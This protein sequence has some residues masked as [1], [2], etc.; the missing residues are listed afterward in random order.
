MEPIAIIGIS[1]RFPG[2][3]DKKAFWQLLRDGVDAI[4]EIPSDRPNLLASY[5]PN[6]KEAGKMSARWGGFLEQVDRFDPHFFG[7]SQR[8]AVA[9]DPQQ[10]L[11][12]EVSW[13]SLEDAGIAPERLAGTRTGVFIGAMWND[14]TQMQMKNPSSIDAYTGSGSGGF[15]M[16]NRLSYR[17]N[18]HGPSMTVDTGC[19]SSLAAVH[20]AC[21][22]L[23]QSE[24][25]LALAGGVNLMLEPGPSVFYTKAGLIAIDGRCKTFD[26]R[27]NG[28]V[29]GEGVG[30]V[31]LKRLSSALS[32]GDPIYAVI[33][34]SAVNHDGLTNGVTAPSQ[35]AQEA[36]LR[37]AYQRAGVSPGQVQYVEAHGTGTLLG[38][39]IEAKALGGVLANDRYPGS[40]CAIG[41]VKTNIGHLEAAAGIAAL[42]KVALALKYRE[43]PPSLHFQEPNPHIPFDILPLRVQQTLSPW[44]KKSGSAL[45]GVSS[46]G[47]GGTNVHMVL[48]EAPVLIPAISDV[49]RPLH[50]L[51]LSAKSENALRAMACCYEA[52]LANHSKVSLVDVCF[53]ANTGRSHFAHRLAL[54]VEST[55]TLREQ[56]SAFAARKQPTGLASGYVRSRKQ[57]KVAFLF[58]GQ[59][60]QYVGMGRQLYDTQPTFRQALERCD[61]LLRPYL[62]QPLLSVL[63]PESSATS[64]LNETA[65]TQPALF[66]LEYALTQLWKLWGIEPDVVMGHSVGE[67][68]AACVAGVF[69]LED[70]L[71]LIATRGQL[72]QR[73][74]HD[75][76]MAVVFAPEA[77]VTVAISPY[78]EAVSIAAINGPEN[79][80]ISGA[81]QAVQAVLR[82]MASE[83]VRTTQLNVS[84]AF[85]SPLMEPMLN[86][87]ERT[88]AEVDY[89]SPRI[90]LI[91]NLT[92]QVVGADELMLAEYWR[93]HIRETVRFSEG[94]EK[95]H[96]QGYDLFVE[97]G[98]SP[99]LSGMGRRCLPEGAG[100]WL[101]SLKK[102]QEDWLQLLDSLRALY[103]GGVEVNWSGFDRDYLR[104]RLSLPT[105]PFERESFWLQT[106]AV[107][108]SSSRQRV[109]QEQKVVESPPKTKLQSIAGQATAEEQ[110]SK[111]AREKVHSNNLSLQSISEA[112]TSASATQ[113]G[114]YNWQWYPESFVES[115]EIPSGAILILKDSQ[116]IAKNLEKLFDAEQYTIYFVASGQKFTQKNQRN[117][118]INPA[119]PEDYERLIRVLKEDGLKITAAIHLWNYSQALVSRMP[120]SSNDPVLYEGVY[121]VLFLGQALMKHYRDCPIDLLVVTQ[122]AYAT[123]AIESLQGLH[124]VMGA[125][126]AQGL[127]Q[128]NATIQTKVVDVTPQSLSSETLAKILFQEM[129]AK[130]SEE[131]I[132]A[133]RQGQRLIRTLER[134]EVSPT[135]NSQ[136]VLTAGETWLITGGTSDVG[137][138]IAKGL[139]SQAPLNLV[140][141]GRHPLPPKK[142]WDRLAGDDT[143]AS[144]RIRV[145]QDL[146]QLGATVMYQAIDVTDAEGMEQLMETIRARFG[147]LDGVIH[148]AGVQDTTSFKLSQKKP[149]TV[150]QV[151]APKVQGTIILDN[152]TQDEPLKSFVVISSAAASKAEWGA[153]LGDYAAANAFLDNYA[154]YRTQG[155]AS[156]RSL[157]VNFSLW[158]DKG[159][160]KI[161]GFALV[162]VAKAKGLNLL[163]PEQAVH[164]FIKALS[165]DSSSV[166]HI[167]DL[168]EQK[169]VEVAPQSSPVQEA[170]VVLQN[171]PTSQPKSKNLRHLVQEILAQYLSIPQEQ[172]E[173]H[174]TFQEL[175]L[176]SIGAIEAIKQLSNT[177]NEEL[178]PTLLFEYQT[179]NDLADYLERQY[180]YA[181]KTVLTATPPSSAEASTSS[182]ETDKPKTQNL[183]KLSIQEQEFKEQD[184]AIIGMAC[185]VPGA[186][187]LEQYWDLLMAGKSAIREVP[188]ERW[189]S[190]DYFEENGTSA[191]TTY[192]KHGGFIERPFD[193]DAMFF[194]ISPREA[195]AIDPQQRLFLEVAWQA[196]QQAGYGGRYRTQDIGV[197]VGCGQNNYV[198]HFINYQQYAVLRRR[199]QESSWFSTLSPQERKR[200]LKTLTEVLQPSEILPETAAGNELNGIAA[201]VSHCLDLKGPSLAVSTACSSSLVALHLA[202]ESLHAG[203]TRMAIVGGVNLNLSPSPYTFLSKVKALSPTGTCYPFDRRA[204]GMV[205]GEGA[206]AVIL[207]PLK[208]AIEDGD[209]IH[210]VIKGSA[211]NNDGHSQGITAPNPRG[212]AEAIRKAYSNAGIDPQTVSYVE[213]HG[214]GTLLGDP[215]EIEG[216]T[217]AF[218]TFTD[219]REFCAI[220]SVKSSIGHMLSAS[221]IV[222][223]IKVAL[224]MQ[225]GKIPGTLGFQ[226]SNPHINFADTPFYAVGERSMSWSGNGSPFRAGVNGFG[227]GGTN[228]HVI[229]EQSPVLSTFKSEANNSSPYLLFLTARN[230]Q[231]LKKVAG[232]LR[233]H[234]L[235]NP[236]QEASQVCFTMNNAQRELSNKA[237]LLVNDRQHMLD[238]LD[239]ICSENTR[240]YIYIGRA[241]PQR[242]TP[243][244][245]VI[246]GSSPL[247]PEEVEILGK[248]FPDF[249][250]AYA[251]CQQH[252]VHG[253]T[254]ENGHHRTGLAGK[255]YAFAV[256]YAL[257]QLLMSLELQ[258]TTLLAQETGILV[259]A[260]LVGMMTLEQAMTLLVQLETHKRINPDNVPMLEE[261]LAS[262]W[263]CPLVTA[264]GIF[265]HPVKVPGLQLAALVQT[266]QPLDAACYREV[267][268]EEGVYLHLGGSLSVRKQ[269]GVLD[270]PHVW[271]NPDKKQPTVNR[272]LA[273]L[274]KLYVAGVRFNSTPL[275]SWNV[276]R[277]P[278]PTYPFERKTYKVSLADSS[279]EDNDTKFD[280]VAN[281]IKE[282]KTIPELSECIVFP[283]LSF[284]QPNA[285]GYEISTAGTRLLP[286]QKLS[287]LSEEQ[288]QSSYI[289]LARE[290]GNFGKPDLDIPK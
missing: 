12:Q 129:K 142:D 266:S 156:G 237:A 112:R 180:G 206:G 19:S 199:L 236:K 29:R 96:Q 239:A 281:N 17:F 248:R 39:P 287:P 288:R 238:A 3:K 13:E 229:V 190:E 192:C 137:G 250:Q 57:P 75:G 259:A 218:R 73:L 52:F 271:I 264:G 214:T 114:F 104:R 257:G 2:A 249:Q 165:M 268:D 20:L 245:L 116:T 203:Q 273:T 290:L 4:T 191:H 228:C 282:E 153:N 215:V 147:H 45:A 127:A 148:A 149:D 155:G 1:C 144:K 175:G 16:A 108:T 152:V 263:A 74:P 6:P 69:S 67:Y 179:P 123:S 24:S 18:F 40:P 194:G 31:V 46:F 184:I 244:H 181:T 207:K 172:L 84:H 141:T 49:E 22:S 61:E 193:F 55:E 109:Q 289:A 43:I 217:Q 274:A 270:D 177:L 197:F 275:F 133:I 65:Y 98:P 169:A 62:D 42:I 85:H 94:I 213:T 195:T 150:T 269:L 247:A 171:I 135:G 131:G 35:W 279:D 111:V 120:V 87:F 158:R 146:E 225:H 71:K 48:E 170:T 226:E 202:S 138:E 283:A 11:L 173:G 230:Q 70:A 64:P 161:G 178:F 212:Q 56:L 63:Y 110:G 232:Q 72:M 277:V 164:A 77:R 103:V 154:I 92:G 113:H 209:F 122:G 183:T 106:E 204:N 124:Q 246:D 115:K 30:V 167:I 51:T 157:A 223:L 47:L 224:A 33:R 79:I 53:T 262:T 23:W 102:G 86:D 272:L 242:V 101:P 163:E 280:S 88:A 60:S 93:H 284:T 198:E 234:I 221:G 168:I 182:I 91:S 253:L 128:E 258:P 82:Q 231:A 140:L 28:I 251:E 126:L 205:L 90:Q 95:L 151:F 50:M 34:G 176:D 159:M 187:N 235:K 130:P 241:N 240:S 66:A 78:A 134:M 200:L 76:E 243:I 26:A 21:Q 188:T 99:I 125:T 41:S 44:S 136:P 9:M 36:L 32:D 7:I 58:T 100:V 119:C 25:T 8:E 210:A 285:T 186:E 38:D 256:Q 121:S 10:R 267:I 5:D 83:G 132:V 162:L 208:Q 97:I 254:Q 220:G 118:T 201:R 80:V 227:F 145:I 68:T 143:T 252:W 37:E 54:A 59:G 174:K 166:I 260:C 278:L 216:M 196:L 139:V 255:A 14:Y 276:R 107:E 286:V 222:S 219:N 189:S 185:K 89:S 81:R 117:F 27:A 160:A 15:M 211:I 105:Y 265:R 233:E 261:A